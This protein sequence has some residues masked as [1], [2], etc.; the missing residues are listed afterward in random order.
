MLAGDGADRVRVDDSGVRGAPA[1]PTTLDGQGGADT[2]IGGRGA[3][4][5]VGGDGNDLLDGNGG[6]DSVEGGAGFDTLSFNGSVGA[7][8][9]RLIADGARARLTR[10]V[11]ASAV[12]SGGVERLDIVPLGGD[13]TLTVGDVAGTG[14]QEVRPDLAGGS[15]RLILN[16]TSEDDSI[17]AISTTA[18]R[19]S[20]IGLPAFVDVVNADPA[21]DEL[22]IN[23]LAGKDRIDGSGTATAFKLVA[24]GG[25][26]NDDLT[27]S[28]GDDTLN[29]GD[30]DD[31]VDGNR[32]ADVVALGAGNDLVTMQAG[33]GRDTLEGQSGNDAISFSGT[34]AGEQFDVSAAGQRVRLSVG[35][36][37]SVDAGNV[38]GLTVF[39]FGGADRLTINDLSGSG[40]TRVDASLFDFGVPGGNQDVVRIDGTGADDAITAADAAGVVTVTGLSAQ[41]RIT[42]T[43]AA[44]DRLEVNGLAGADT[45]DSTEL[46]P[47]EMQVR[48]DGGAGKRR[49]SGRR[50]RRRPV[51]RRRR[52]RGVR[53]ERRQRRLRRERRRRPARRGGRRLLRRRPWRRHPDRQWRRRRPAERRGGV[54][55]LRFSARA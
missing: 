25:P 41:V 2:L 54:R 10:D 34:A 12:D 42:G 48:A 46:S 39:S 9:L 1:P 37:V 40:L 4:T 19:A 27:G 21:S 26:G 33:D 6:S 31:F 22:T 30:G 38:E 51:R 8:Q 55:R 16:A 11:G 47:A 28:N 23:G 18:G 14:V 52:G 13:D 29:G 32:G 3:D 43:A 50:R 45:I 17:N 49:P 35:G 7:D 20:V 53:R 24:D 15:D 44:G 36:A 5:L